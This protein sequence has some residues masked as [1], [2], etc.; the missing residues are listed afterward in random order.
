MVTTLR[1]S[2]VNVQQGRE[3]AKLR[4]IE[5]ISNDFFY[6]SST[7]GTFLQNNSTNTIL[8]CGFTRSQNESFYHEVGGGAFAQYVPSGAVH[9]EMTTLER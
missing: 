1:L 6:L 9:L 5:T 8:I 2:I 7:T 4:T 3:V